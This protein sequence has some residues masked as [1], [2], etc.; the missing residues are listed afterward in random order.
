VKWKTMDRGLDIEVLWWQVKP[1][2]HV[3]PHSAGQS[4]PTGAAVPK[5]GAD[6]RNQLP[7]NIHPR[8][9]DAS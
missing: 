9:G 3:S 2:P 8:Y 4:Q 5:P 6:C 7:A 1:V